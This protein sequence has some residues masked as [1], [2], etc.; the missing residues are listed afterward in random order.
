MQLPDIKAPTSNTGNYL[1]IK[2]GESVRGVFIGEIHTFYIKWT[3]GKSHLSVPNDPEARVRF[4]CNFALPDEAGNLTVKVWEFSF[5]VFSVI[6]QINEEYPLEQ[7]KV[8]I[9]RIGQGTETTHQILPLVGQKDVLTPQQLKALSTLSLH[10]LDKSKPKV[11]LGSEPP[12]DDSE[13]IP[14]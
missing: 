5:P 14:F 7:T 13:E 10:E 4:K 9:T 1:K 12:F 11:S 6:K 3:N 2:P 8:K